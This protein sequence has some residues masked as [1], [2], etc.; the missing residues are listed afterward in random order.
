MCNIADTDLF[1]TASWDKT[2][3]IWNAEFFIIIFEKIIFKLQFFIIANK[4]NL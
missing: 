4:N 2:A 1:V 3:K